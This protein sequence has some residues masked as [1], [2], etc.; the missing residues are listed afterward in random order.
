MGA[1]SPASRCVCSSGLVTTISD[2]I[3]QVDHWTLCSSRT[4]PSKSLKTHP[5]RNWDSLQLESHSSGVSK[6]PLNC[7]IWLWSECPI[8]EAC[9]IP[10]GWNIPSQ[11][12][13]SP[14][15]SL[16][17]SVLR[18]CHGPPRAELSV[19]QVKTAMQWIMTFVLFSIFA[20]M[21]NTSL[22]VF[23]DTICLFYRCYTGN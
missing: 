8:P 4:Q 16:P 22:D 20:P 23:Q 18:S 17:F 21:V 2:W 7:E 11:L 6:P 15:T 14:L 9:S 1:H 19:F 12:G 10:P 3:S 13:D 5:R